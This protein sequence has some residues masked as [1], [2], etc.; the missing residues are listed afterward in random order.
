MGAQIMIALFVKRSLGKRDVLDESLIFGTIAERME[1]LG[2]PK[3]SSRFRWR[4]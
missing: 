2:F 4:S 3:G 1:R